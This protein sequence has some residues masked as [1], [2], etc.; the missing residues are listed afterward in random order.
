ME[1]NKLLIFTIIFLLDIGTSHPKR[2]NPSS[3]FLLH[4]AGGVAPNLKND[5][6]AQFPSLPSANPSPN[7]N[8]NSAITTKPQSSGKRD[9]VAPQRSTNSPTSSTPSKPTALVTNPT[10]PNSPKRDY[11]APQW[12]TLKPVGSTQKQGNAWTT[13]M[14]STAPKRDYVAPNFP[15]MKQENNQNAGKVKDLINFYDSKSP[16]GTTSRPSYSSIL[17]G[18]KDNQIPSSKATQSPGNTPKPLSFSSV[19]SGPKNPNSGVPLTTITTPRTSSKP[20]YSNRNQFNNRPSSPVLPSSLANNNQVTNSNEPTDTELQTVSEELL[21]KDVNNAARY[22]TVNYQTKTTSQSKDDKAPSPLLVIS[23]DVW[24]IPTV[25]QFLPLLDNYERDTLINEHVTPQER[26]E[27]NNFIDAIMATSVI[28]HLMNFLKDKGYVSPDPKQQRD[29]LKQIWFGLYSRG[30]GKISSSGFEHIFVS[31]LKNGEVSGLHNWLYFSKEE[32]ANRINYLG[33]LKYVEFNDKGAVIKMHFNQQG[34]DKPVDTMFIGT[35]PE[36]EIA[37][38]TLCYVTRVGNDCKLKLGNKD[39]E[40]V[41]HNFRYRSKN[42]I[43]S[44]YPQI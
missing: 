10:S 24:N 5:Y 16:S 20:S 11:V 31:E 33:Y 28:R 44:A 1:S 18:Q 32:V 42:Y 30:K 6:A 34:V 3:D 22:I 15:S 29:F 26:T 37:I 13:P 7:V 43:G 4:E 40:I 38:Y 19:A 12:P 41:T 21:R 8:V 14:P 17:N 25:Q 27:E 9:Y 23:P 35:S 2:Y 39:V 36:L